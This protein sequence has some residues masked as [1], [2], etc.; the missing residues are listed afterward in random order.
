MNL[1][2]W[3]RIENLACQC[4]NIIREAF[5]NFVHTGIRD[6]SV[7]LF[8]WVKECLVSN[9][10]EH[11]RDSNFQSPTCASGSS[12]KRKGFNKKGRYLNRSH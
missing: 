7:K 5:P 4:E 6:N 10:R 3:N 12:N 8:D 2:P 11:K 9:A 1:K